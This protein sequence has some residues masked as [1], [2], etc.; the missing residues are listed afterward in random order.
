LV[1][2]SQARPFTHKNTMDRMLQHLS[3]WQQN[4][5]ICQGLLKLLPFVAHMKALNA[6]EVFTPYPQN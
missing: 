4:G 1:I 5:V 6:L 2:G 3:H